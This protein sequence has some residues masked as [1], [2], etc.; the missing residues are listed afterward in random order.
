[1]A[2]VTA[3]DA[4]LREQM[5]ALADGEL[6][7]AAVQT[8]CACWQGDAELRA[9]WHAYHLIGDVLRSEDLAGA[10]A[11]DAAFLGDL[12]IRLAREAIVLAPQPLAAGA[13]R[14]RRG[15]YLEAHGGDR[16]RWMISS[17]IAAGFVAIVGTYVV[18]RPVGPIAAPTTLASAESVASPVTRVDDRQVAEANSGA[19]AA[20]P[21]ALAGDRLIR[22]ARLDAYLAAHKQFAG[23]SVL[24]VPS[25]F[26]R[27][28]TVDASSGR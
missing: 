5:S 27:S 17:A 21:T 18:M 13:E 25:A 23:S 10:P 3:I 2:T 19:A 4:A 28:A 14:G 1:M 15:L 16:R 22:D 26:L 8:A 20:R 6:E 11:R 9:T 12:R 7:P 24:G